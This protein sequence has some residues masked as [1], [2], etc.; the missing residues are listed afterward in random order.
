MYFRTQFKRII[1]FPRMLLWALFMEG[2]ETKQMVQTYAR[3]H[4]G[5]LLLI[6]KSQRPTK[7][8]LQQAR[9]QLRDIPRFLPFFV[10]IAVPAPGVTEGYALLAITLE[11]WLGERI[12]LLPSHFR[13][14]F[15]KE[16]KPMP[17]EENDASKS[18]SDLT[19]GQNLTDRNF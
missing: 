17:E 11:R 16:K 19:D 5:R 14:V 13:K 8:E 12:S 10:I 9:E 6:S 1:R 15:Q 4:A 2:V 18:D 3:H 7:E